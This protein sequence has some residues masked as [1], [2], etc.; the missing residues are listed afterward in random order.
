MSVLLSGPLIKRHLPENED[1]PTETDRVTTIS[2]EE[3]LQDNGSFESDEQK[4]RRSEVLF[5]L[6]D[7]VNQFVREVYVKNSNDISGAQNYYGKLIAFGSFRYDVSSPE[8]DIDSLCIVPQFVKRT[9]FFTIFYRLLSTNQLVK[10]LV[11]IENAYVPIITMQFQGIDVDIS[12]AQLALPNIDPEMD[13]S[14]LDDDNI[15]SNV[16]AQSMRSLNG[17]RVSN[18]IVRLVDDK[19]NF[20]LFLR[21]IRMWAKKRGVYGNVY[22]YLGGVNCALLCAF[23]CQRYP[24]ALPSKLV[25][26]FFKDLMSWN[27]PDPIYINT[28][29]IGPLPS[30]DNNQGSPGKNDKMPIITPAYP[31]MNSMAKA[32]KSTRDR[33][34]HE[35]KRGYKYTLKVFQEGEEWKCLIQ[36]THFFVNCRKYV[37]V[38]VWASTA[39]ELNKWV[40][41]VEAQIRKLTLALES[42][43]FMNAVYAYPKHFDRQDDEGHEF[44]S[45]FFLGLEYCIPKEESVERRIDI[46]E[47]AQKFIDDMY[48]SPNRTPQMGLF[49]HLIDRMLMV[50]YVFEDGRPVKKHRKQKTAP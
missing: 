13:I 36:P 42:V 18:M 39:E 7:L 22:G 5:K 9:D 6:E 27:W 11:K 31:A 50:P 1:P 37:R 20:A 17:V 48:D 23:I 24:T 33:M 46:S 2:L 8:S 16:D 21:F 47:Y 3:F 34:V 29:A 30:W 49:M 10:N 35:F 25:L 45:N 19:A 43:R 12:F 32:T 41:T 4:E 28:P 38:Q 26:M 40:Q 44:S 15:L 14:L